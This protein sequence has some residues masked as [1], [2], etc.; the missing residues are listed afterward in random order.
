MVRGLFR[1]VLL[2]IVVALVGAYMLG[3]R[4]DGRVYRAD[5]PDTTP[6]I[7]ASGEKARDVART[8]GERA[9][10]AADATR[11]ALGEG[12]LTAKIK[13]KMALDDHV[14]AFDLNVDTAG[15][16]VTVTG[17]VNTTAERDRALELARDTEGVTQV[18]D[19]LQVKR[20]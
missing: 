16:V 17:T 20:K 10:Q 11:R 9:S 18:V 19:R 14:K 12:S 4:F 6:R 8:A 5:A 13:A 7:D 3:W 2:L 1:L 15:S